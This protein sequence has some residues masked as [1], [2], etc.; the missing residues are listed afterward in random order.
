ML[1]TEY[2]LQ[3]NHH[4]RPIKIL[5]IKD[6]KRDVCIKKK[7]NSMCRA[8]YELERYNNLVSLFDHLVDPLIPYHLQI[9]IVKFNVL[10]KYPQKK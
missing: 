7:R 6:L 5:I 2:D 1:R 3:S 9:I 4:V 8:H 10:Y